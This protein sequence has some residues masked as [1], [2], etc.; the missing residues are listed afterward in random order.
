MAKATKTD[1][2]KQ[3]EA[4]I[5]WITTLV[6]VALGSIIFGLLH[7]AR[8]NEQSEP[9]TKIREIANIELKPTEVAPPP[10]PEPAEPVIEPVPEP[11]PVVV[12]EPEPPEP[13]SL[14]WDDF[15]DRS[16]LWPKTLEIVVDRKIDLIYQGKSYG[17]IEFSSGQK[18]EVGELSANGYLFGKTNGLETEI[19]ASETNLLAWFDQEHGTEFELTYPDKLEIE[20]VD[21]FEQQLIT[22]MRIW[23]M[24]NYNT[25]LIELGEEK[26][27]LRLKPVSKG[28]KSV[29]GYS[30]EALSVARAYLR[31]QASLGGDDVYAS[32]EIR[33][34]VTDE[35]LGSEGMIIPRF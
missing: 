24:T 4:K 32:C 16:D 18:F 1:Q 8:T 27:I 11:E 6:Y 23:S 13:E 28:G 26:L 31:I 14:A 30:L 19:H 35:L 29:Q 2:Q 34:S 22:E 15:M 12:E 21:G 20:K 9:A 5:R 3:A 25:P 33:H 10:E 17:E 7:W